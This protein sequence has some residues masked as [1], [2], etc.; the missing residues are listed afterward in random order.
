M[1][2]E[3]KEF[4]RDLYKNAPLSD[5]EVKLLNLL[6]ETEAMRE[7]AE[8]ELQ[9]AELEKELVDNELPISALHGDPRHNWSDSDWIEAK[10]KEL[11][12]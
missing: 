7:K 12:G 8:V 1:T 2:P 5:R 11:V 10:R 3:D 4:V 9:V 6:V